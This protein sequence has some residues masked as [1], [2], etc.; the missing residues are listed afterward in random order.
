MNSPLAKVNRTSIVLSTSE[1]QS[2][3]P[4]AKVNRTDYYSEGQLSTSDGHSYCPLA[5]VN[6]VNSLGHR[7]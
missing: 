2:Y 1:G 6:S 4:L 5:K 7:T 3:C